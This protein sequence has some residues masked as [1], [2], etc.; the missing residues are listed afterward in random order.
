MGALWLS[1]QRPL[2]GKFFMRFAP[3]GVAWLMCGAVLVAAN[4]SAPPRLRVNKSSSSFS[5]IRPRDTARKF[6]AT[7][8]EKTGKFPANS[9]PAGNSPTPPRTPFP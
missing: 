9:L 2:A 3:A 8:P 1:L 7:T 4:I 6:P 5:H